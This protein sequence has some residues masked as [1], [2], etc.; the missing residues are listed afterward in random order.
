MNNTLQHVGNP[1][2]QAVDG[3]DKV[4]GRTKYV[5]D[6]VLDG[7]L[8]V[9]L[10]LSPL[11][12]ALISQ[13][14]TEPA[15][16]VPGV[17]AVITSADFPDNGAFGWPI[18]DDFVLAHQKVRYVGEP[19]AAVAAETEKA[20]A[21]GVRAIRLELEKLPIV[22]DPAHALDADAP[23]IP[24]DPPQDSGNLCETLIVRNGNPE[25]ILAE[26][27]TVLDEIYYFQHQDHAYLE[28][29]GAL[30]I[31]EP[32]GGVTIFANDQSPHINRG[33]ASAIL[34]LAEDEVRIIQPPVGGSFGGKDDIVYQ[35]TGITAR[36]ALMTKRP[37]RLLLTREE[38][39]K[40]SYK[41]EAMQ[42]GLTIGMDNEGK[43]R[44]GKAAILADSGAFA[45][46][47]TLAAWRASMHALGT[48]RYE[49]AHV[50][51]QVV[52]TNNGYSGAFRGFG[53]TQ[54]AAASEIAIDELAYLADE[55][56]I[57]FRLQNILQQD[58]KAFTGNTIEYESGLQ[59]CLEWV[60]KQSDWSTKREDYPKSNL[61]SD[62]VQ[63]IGVACYFHGSGLGGEGLDYARATLQVNQD[64][65]ITLQSGLTD[66]GQGSRTVFTLVAAETLGVSPGR[67]QMLRPDTHTALETG[68][69][70]AS[71][72]SIVGGNAT[73]V[74]A[75]KIKNMLQLAAA[76]LLSCSTE[77]LFWEDET[78]IG[79]SE[80]PV[81]LE[82][83]IDHAFAMGLQLS[84]R[85]YWQLPEIHWDLATGSGVPYS[86]YSYG[87]QIA[88]VTVNRQTG[89][90]TVNKIWA[91]HDGGQIIYPNGAKGQLLG[92]IAQ[93]LGYALTEGFSYK[94][95]YPQKK[96]LNQYH[97][98]TSLDVPE[99]ESTF[100]ET[101][102]PI[103]PFG[104]KNLA[105][106]VMI[107]TTPAIANAVFHACG[108]R[109]RSFPIPPAWLRDQL[110]DVTPS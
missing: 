48:Y 75:E 73:R 32:D 68:P 80:I 18:K 104:A 28:M 76:D 94:D 11:P 37:V 90:V 78:V 36:L 51:T 87:A 109:C 72:A 41:R 66:Y 1:N 42:I 89:D 82:A 3:L 64:H 95:S 105:E 67:I 62:L 71:R 101:T 110:S 53:N 38:S 85:G 23:L 83:V 96:N 91:A 102:F 4:L 93:G 15:L 50:D 40:S 5:G 98:P 46:M 103:G 57:E 81:S 24:L 58:D 74:A 20:A 14:N 59:K 52:Y 43:V 55:D 27:A 29:E 16:N 33:N 45:S 10:L 7:M 97:I 22:S 86:T 49:A 60:R 100:V 84:A 8:H 106:P 56:P 9:K 99:I 44:A 30:A 70:V 6:M 39:L 31:P 69:T 107:A 108:V 19:V 88:D 65:T 26:C 25:P 21:K 61:H 13:I 79:P 17:K 2:V 63:G 92:G 77:Q 12:H 34:G 54:S 47:T 35:L